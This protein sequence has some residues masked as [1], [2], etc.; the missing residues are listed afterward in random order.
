[1]CA[2]DLA[3]AK[4]DEVAMTGPVRPAHSMLVGPQ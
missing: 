3:G 2:I 4:R 1:M